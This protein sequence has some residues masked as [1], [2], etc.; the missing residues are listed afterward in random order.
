M[1]S[2]FNNHCRMKRWGRL[3]GEYCQMTDF[4]G[5]LPLAAWP[6]FVWY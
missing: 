1:A 6:H 3:S 2:F 5:L 4:A